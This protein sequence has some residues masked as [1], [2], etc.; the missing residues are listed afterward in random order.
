VGGASWLALAAGENEQAPTPAAVAPGQCHVPAAA[1]ARAAG[2]QRAQ[3]DC[4]AGCKNCP[5]AKDQD[6]DGRCD[7]AKDCARHA[8]SCATAHRTGACQTDAVRCRGAKCGDCKAADGNRA[9]DKVA[10]CGQQSGSACPGRGKGGHGK[11]GGCHATPQQPEA[12]K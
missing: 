3:P 9:C 5:D 12:A 6:G 2:C 11:R 10:G 7:A 1:C 8:G 4:N